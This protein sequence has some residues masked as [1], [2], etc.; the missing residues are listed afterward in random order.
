M[1]APDTR[2]FSVALHPDDQFYDLMRVRIE[3]RFKQ[4]G[5]SGSEWRFSYVAELLRKGRLVAS[6]R[7]GSM[8]VAAVQLAAAAVSDLASLEVSDEWEVA[9]ESTWRTEGYCCQPG[10]RS[11]ATRRY[12][13]RR[14]YDASCSLSRPNTGDG[15]PLVREFC[16]AH[17][18]RGTSGLDDG[19]SNYLLLGEVH[20][21]PFEPREMLLFL[22]VT[23][24]PHPV[25]ERDFEIAHTLEYLGLCKVEHHVIS[26]GGDY[27]E[28]YEG[29]CAFIT[30]VGHRL[31]VYQESNR[32]R[33]AEQLLLHMLK[34]KDD[35]N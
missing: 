25:R 34:L 9:D 24:D 21:P 30:E 7:W 29:P 11:R 26:P 13:L 16:E 18:V 20:S 2:D 5:L 10:C 1:P 3:P 35:L 6:S 14:V 33:E 28:G 15:A 31:V 8:E 23:R 17:S 4:S 19:D 32:H 22:G 12:L 27:D